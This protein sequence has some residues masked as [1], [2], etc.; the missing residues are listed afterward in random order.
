LTGKTLV[1]D[2]KYIEIKNNTKGK[3]QT[4]KVLNIDLSPNQR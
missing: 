4:L 2:K 1:K 3:T